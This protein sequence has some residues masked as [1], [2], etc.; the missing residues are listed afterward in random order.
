[1]CRIGLRQPCSS[2]RKLCGAHRY[3]PKTKG[4]IAQAEDKGRAERLEK[5]RRGIIADQQARRTVPVEWGPDYPWSTCFKMLARH[6][7]YWSEEVRHPASASLA[8][9][10]VGAAL[11]PAE[12][13]AVTHLAGGTDALATRLHRRKSLTV[14]DSRIATRDWLRGGGSKK[15][16]PSWSS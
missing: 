6:D 10:G 5:I 16:E 4:L 1:M 3:W 2:T 12:A 7:T 14:G 9:G 8:A 15:R 11:A 13:I